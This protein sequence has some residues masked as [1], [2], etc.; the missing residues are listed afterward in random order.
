MA[1]SVREWIARREVR[2][3]VDPPDPDHRCKDCHPTD[4][5]VFVCP[6]LV[7]AISTLRELGVPVNAWHPADQL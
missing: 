5:D 4:P 3:H 6:R 7:A 2:M 1:R